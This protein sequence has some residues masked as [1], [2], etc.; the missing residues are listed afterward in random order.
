MNQGQHQGF[1]LNFWKNRVVVNSEEGWEGG[2]EWML[3]SGMQ[4]RPWRGKDAYW[5]SRWRTTVGR[6]VGGEHKCN[7][8]S[9]SISEKH[10]LLT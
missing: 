4:F 3:E 5:T 2:F 9:W 10:P 6:Q 8:G 1:H 7:L